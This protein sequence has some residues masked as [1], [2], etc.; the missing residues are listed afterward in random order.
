MATS[1]TFHF[2][3]GEY[4][5]KMGAAW[6][7]SYKY[8]QV[9][10]KNHMNWNNEKYSEL[11]ITSRINVFDRTSEYHYFWLTKVLDMQQLDKHINFC[12]LE[13]SEI[14]KMAATII[15]KLLDKK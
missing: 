2:E 9:I 4:L 14:I 1:H 7:V 5:T 12:G 10:D 13:S 11:S 6:F 8:H 3:G 15:V